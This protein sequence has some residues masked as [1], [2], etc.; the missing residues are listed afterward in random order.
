V[1]AFRRNSALAV[2]ANYDLKGCMLKVNVISHQTKAATLKN[3]VLSKPLN[4]VDKKCD[5]LCRYVTIH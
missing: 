3:N 5:V 1:L 2:A 4:M